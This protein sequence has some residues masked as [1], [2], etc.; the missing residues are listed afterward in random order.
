MRPDERT[1]RSHVDAGPFQ[2]GIERQ[3]WRLISIEWPYAVI[4]VATPARQNAPS[5]VALRFELSDYPQQPPTAQPWDISAD[6]PLPPAL[7][8]VGGQA[9]EVFKPEWNSAALYIPC[10]RVAIQ[11]HPGWVGQHPGHLWHP[12]LDISHY[13]RVVRNVLNSSGYA[14]VRQQAA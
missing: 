9:G 10:D 6:A 14:G 5:E 1:F 3:D 11:G 7:W 8:P 12:N 4:A 2:S 13:L